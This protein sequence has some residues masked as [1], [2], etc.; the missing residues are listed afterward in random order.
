MVEI[1]K[2]NINFTSNKEVLKFI[3]EISQK[4]NILIVNTS[5]PDILSIKNS[6]IE[7]E[8]INL[9]NILI[10]RYV[11]QTFFENYFVFDNNS[12]DKILN[13]KRVKNKVEKFTWFFLPLLTEKIFSE[14]QSI[15]NEKERNKITSTYFRK[16]L[17]VLLIFWDKV[18]FDSIEEL[19][20]FDLSELENIEKKILK[21]AKILEE[22]E[23][24]LN[25]SLIKNENEKYL[26]IFKIYLPSVYRIANKKAYKSFFEYSKKEENI[27]EEQKE[28]KLKEFLKEELEKEISIS[29][30][31]LYDLFIKATDLNVGLENILPRLKQWFDKIIWYIN[32]LKNEGIAF[33]DNITWFSN[34]NRFY[35][36]LVKHEL[37]NKKKHDIFSN[38]LWQE[39][40]NNFDDI[41]NDIKSLKKDESKIELKTELDKNINLSNVSLE[42]WDS[43]VPSVAHRIFI[44]KILLLDNITWKI[45]FNNNFITKNFN[46][47]IFDDFLKNFATSLWKEETV[48]SKQVYKIIDLIRNNDWITLN[49]FLENDINDIQVLYTLWRFKLYYRIDKK[50]KEKFDYIPKNWLWQEINHNLVTKW[51]LPSDKLSFT[52]WWREHNTSCTNPDISIWAVFESLWKWNILLDKY[53]IW[54]YNNSKPR[55]LKNLEKL[56]FLS[57]DSTSTDIFMHIELWIDICIKL[58]QWNFNFNSE[59]QKYIWFLREYEIIPQ[60]L[61]KMTNKDKN[62]LKRLKEWLG[63]IQ[64]KIPTLEKMI[65]SSEEIN[66]PI[67]KLYNKL[68]YLNKKINNILEKNNLLNWIWPKKK[69]WR[70]FVKLI[71]KYDWDFHQLWDLNRLRLSFDNIDD[72]KY[73]FEEFVKIAKEPN[74]LIKS[75]SVDDWTWNILSLPKKKTWYKDYKIQFTLD[76]WNTVEFQFH[77]SKMLETKSIWNEINNKMKT[78]LEEEESLL[79]K[80]ELNL[81]LDLFYNFHKWKNINISLLSGL[82][83][84][85][86]EKIN[87]IINHKKQI[88]LDW[89]KIISADNLY[90]ICRNLQKN[91]TL[92]EKLTRLER[93][94][95]DRSWVYVV[96][97]Y[98][99]WIWIEWL[100]V[101]L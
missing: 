85:E 4:I 48:V 76:T 20:D 62:N 9:L 5:N 25:S 35:P 89:I 13:E 21:N 2:T 54:N 94:L 58:L 14:I 18:N 71:W 45:S 43:L 41:I 98:L 101:S 55:Y 67:Y 81:F 10:P 57:E 79:N 97:Q 52:S 99:T 11:D 36:V 83:W 93:I 91:S 78:K 70:A 37:K 28:N 86:E 72:L 65:K 8:I 46:K 1:I 84:L 29:Y 38:F 7:E 40:K 68:H 24:E 17:K 32:V 64:D 75:I 74:S 61:D 77:Y 12:S 33:T 96:K 44:K 63:F 59:E 90:E 92:F 51:I 100:W 6:W 23:I 60:D 47:K 56:Y 49:D 80:E 73:V 15:N 95:F 39:D 53:Q 87:E 30:K 19:L 66:E 22:K 50:N 69:F 42:D 27:T 26:S 82:S 16:F 34:N 31:K 88:N 3:K